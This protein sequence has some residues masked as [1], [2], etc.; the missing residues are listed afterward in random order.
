MELNVEEL[1]EEY[2]KYISHLPE[3]LENLRNDIE[4]AQEVKVVQGIKDFS[5]GLKW[6]DSL[7]NYLINN[8]LNLDFSLLDISEQLNILLDSFETKDYVLMSDVIEYELIP[9][10]ENL[11]VES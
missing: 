6:L 9:Y 10:F 4:E 11:K 8:N 3:G 2:T 5:E 7:K 1:L